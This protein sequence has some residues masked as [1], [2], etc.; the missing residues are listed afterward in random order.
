[1]RAG[2]AGFHGPHQRQPGAND[3]G[4]QQVPNHKT[5][6]KRVEK[7]MVVTATLTTPKRWKTIIQQIAGIK[8]SEDTKVADL[9]I[10]DDG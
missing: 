9:K 5:R 8:D 4:D 10:S 2:S 1:M 6:E 7:P 3:Q